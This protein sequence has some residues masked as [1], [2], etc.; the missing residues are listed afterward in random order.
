MLLYKDSY[1]I[2]H[3]SAITE[4]LK[5]LA[6]IVVEDNYDEVLLPHPRKRYC[7]DDQHLFCTMLESASQERITEKRICRCW[8]YFNKEDKGQ[9]CSACKFSFKKSNVGNFQI[10][11]Y[12]VPTE[13]AMEQ[14][15]G[16]DWLLK[17]DGRLIAAEVKP[18]NS[19]ET[20]V[21]MIAEI[22]TYTIGTAY[23]PAIC[24]FKTDMGGNPSKQ[25]IDYL[26]YRDNQD[27]QLILSRTCLEVLYV[28]FDK[29]T[30]SIHNVKD[31]PI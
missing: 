25:Y 3:R 5:E 29:D 30:F 20:I 28:T 8:C 7:H 1:G 24:F 6:Q 16:I 4:K 27:F 2:N 22:L 10:S 11:D 9:D 17:H 13:F 15:G 26:K 19:S 14:L 21:R 23:V 18:P 31:K 12:E